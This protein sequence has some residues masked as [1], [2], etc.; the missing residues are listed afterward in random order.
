MRILIINSVCGIRSTGRICTDLATAFE[1][2]GHQV[3][4]AYGREK[5]PEKYK[6]YAIRIGSRLDFGLS[7]I[8]TRLTDKHG[9]ANDRATKKF[10]CWAEKYNPDML[11]LHNL[12]GYYINIELLF[13]W[14][15]SRPQMQ[16]KWTLHDCWAFTGH[17]PHFTRIK[18]NKWKEECYGC[19]Q[20]RTYP[21]SVMLDNSKYNYRK[22]K[23]VFTGVKDLTIITPSQWLANLVK[24]SYLKEYSV[25]IQY[26][27]IDKTVFKPT[28][29]NF[30][31]ENGLQ[32]KKILLGVAS[33]W[34]ESKGLQD[35]LSLYHM[36]DASYA[37]VLVGLT[38][39]QVKQIKSQMNRKNTDKKIFHEKNLCDLNIKEL[40][41]GKVVP[42]DVNILYQVITE[43]MSV[44]DTSGKPIFIGISTTNDAKELAEIYTAADIF[45]NPT[46][47]DTYPTVNL[48]AKACGTYVI[49]YD[50][51]GCLE[52]LMNS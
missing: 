46:Y 26:N 51:G 41:C 6:K 21:S 28:M 47:Q 11:W 27:S 49:T 7:V 38:R 45:V 1:T 25:E 15:K 39:K 13:E 14:I 24:Q 52:T 19:T 40:G 30:R 10:I 22:K 20:G 9:F 18:C 17:C 29:S 35:F 31:Q 43:R 12:H 36:L 16:V 33:S 5:V 32:D 8:H 4:I 50:T 42:Q 3:K 48:E 34:S 37:I 44:S 23:E 2:K